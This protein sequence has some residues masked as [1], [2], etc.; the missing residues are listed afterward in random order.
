MQ[1]AAA[2]SLRLEVV[3]S[4][5]ARGASD[6][7]DEDLVRLSNGLSR[8]LAALERLAAARAKAKGSGQS[9]LAE[10]LASRAAEA[11]A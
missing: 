7:S 8:E 11:V 2:L 10:Y 5:L 1:S 6:C 3:R 9:A 4:G